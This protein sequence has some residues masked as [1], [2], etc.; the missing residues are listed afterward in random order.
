MKVERDSVQFSDGKI[1]PMVRGSEIQPVRPH[2]PHFIECKSCAES[3]EIDGEVLYRCRSG[4]SLVFPCPKCGKMKV[5]AIESRLV[6]G[7]AIT[8]PQD[9]T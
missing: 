6:I 9:L 2:E 5:I 7:D 4:N 1:V 3:L 8:G